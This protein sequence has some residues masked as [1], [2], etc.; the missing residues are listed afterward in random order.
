MSQLHAAQHYNSSV[1]DRGSAVTAGLVKQHIDD[2][3]TVESKHTCQAQGAA[4]RIRRCA[5]LQAQ[6]HAGRVR[7]QDHHG[8]A[9][10]PDEVRALQSEV[11]I[12]RSLTTL[13]GASFETP[14]TGSGPLLNLGHCGA[15]DA[16]LTAVTSQTQQGAAAARDHGDARGNLR[17]RLM[18]RNPELHPEPAG[19][20]YM[21]SMHSA[22]LYCHNHWCAAAAPAPAP[23]R[24]DR[25]A[26]LRAPQVCHRDIAE[27]TFES[28]GDEAQLK[29]I[30]FGLAVEQGQGEDGAAGGRTRTAHATRLR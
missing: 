28:P 10:G 7:A 5:D 11:D 21:R 4:R 27:T 29:L 3:V 17:D 22:I 20:K 26:L 9:D 1:E 8:R 25:Q 16:A 24:R 6:G 14:S 2:G 12:L 19:A 18:N 23:A 15:P 30:D 13:G